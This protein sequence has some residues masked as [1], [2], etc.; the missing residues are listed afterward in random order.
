MGRIPGT[1]RSVAPLAP[2]FRGGT[3]LAMKAT[4]AYTDVMSDA[5]KQHRPRPFAE[6]MAALIFLTRLPIPWK[7]DWPADL[8]RRAMAWFPI[9]GA[10]LGTVGGLCYWFLGIAGLS[11]LLA[12]IVTVAA[13]TWLTGALHEDGLADMADGFGGGR[14]REAKLAIM[15]DSRVGTYGSMALILA[16]LARVGVL[17]T[18]ADPRTVALALIGAHAF[19]RGLLPLARLALPDARQQG[20]A[21]RNGRPDSARALVAALI[22]FTLATTSLAKL[23]LDSGFV[24]LCVMAVSAGAIWVV[25]QLAR[26]QIGGVTGDV[27]GAGQQ[28]GEIGF[29]LALAAVIPASA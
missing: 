6:F 14:D 2:S 5:T 18:L 23:H 22:G 26:R 27:L 8:D 10:L 15:K 12:A 11:P 3:V 13:L 24:S 28:M 21:A 19:S 4:L 17:A 20:L 9:V 25:A 7:G 16:V 29:L 1:W